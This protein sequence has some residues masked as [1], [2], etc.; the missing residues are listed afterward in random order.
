M[1]AVRFPAVIRNMA[2][3]MLAFRKEI[4]TFKGVE[5]LLKVTN[6]TNSL[7]AIALIFSGVTDPRQGP[8]ASGSWRA[9]ES[10]RF[11]DTAGGHREEGGGEGVLGLAWTPHGSVW[12]LIPPFLLQDFSRTLVVT[13]AT[14]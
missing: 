3:E 6:Q 13:M 2:F 5:F 11:R 10:D 8:G 1:F 4:Q 9:P 12:L 14:Y 7:F